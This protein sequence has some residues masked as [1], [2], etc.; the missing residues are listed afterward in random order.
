MNGFKLPIRKPI[1][2]EVSTEF[3]S[4]KAFFHQKQFASLGIV[5]S[6]L[7][8]PMVAPVQADGQ[9]I[10]ESSCSG[11]HAGGGNILPFSGGKTL[12]KDALK[13]NGY[14]TKEAVIKIVTEGR[15]AM[16]P[17]G[18]FKSPVG[19][20]MPAFLQP[21]QIEAVSAYVIKQAANDW[22]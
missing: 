22:K 12:F 10:F 14:D 8:A 3:S 16:I 4:W 5:A 2:R 9:K 6:V 20:E 7:L 18:P 19:N 13:S 1:A 15:G 21:N 17:Y 11:C